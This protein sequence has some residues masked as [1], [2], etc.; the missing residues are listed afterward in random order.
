M[1]QFKNEGDPAL[2]LAEECAEVIQVISKLFRFHGSWYDIPP[3]KTETR[4]DELKSE[5]D[6]LLF[7]WDR[8]NRERD[9]YL[10]LPEPPMP[11]GE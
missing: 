4:W 6:D 2:A 5:M 8:L 1:G 11:Y 10:E 9:K 7:Q 3:G